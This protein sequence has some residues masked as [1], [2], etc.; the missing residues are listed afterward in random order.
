MN[1]HALKILS[2]SLLAAALAF[3]AAPAFAQ[4]E[5]HTMP[6]PAPKPAAKKPAPKPAAKSVAKPS[7][8]EDLIDV[9]DAQTPPGVSMPKIALS[10]GARTGLSSE[11]MQAIASIAPSDSDLKRIEIGRIDDISQLLTLENA[12]VGYG[13]IVEQK[14]AE[15][16][17]FALV[18]AEGQSVDLGLRRLWSAGFKDA[19]ALRDE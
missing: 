19:F 1:T 14:S 13:E 18:V 10:Y 4:H 17:S 15:G 6:M 12:A 7:S 11:A 3:P 2:V 5:G 8:I 9:Y 16:S